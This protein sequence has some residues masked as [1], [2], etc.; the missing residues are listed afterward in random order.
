MIQSMTGYGTGLARRDETSVT[1][2]IRTVNHRFLDMHIRVPRD[3]AYLEMDIQ[4]VIRGALTRGRVD[5]SVSI[6]AAASPELL[7]NSSTVRT[8][9][10][11]AALLRDKFQFQDALDLKTL[12]SLPGVL[13]NREA[14]MGAA[15]DRGIQETVLEALKQALDGVSTMRRQEGG[16]LHAEMTRHLDSIRGRTDS[17]G[18]LAPGTVMEYKSKLEER[19]A[20]LLPQN[21]L[22]PQRVAMEVALLAEKSDISEEV[23]RLRSHTEQFSRM[24]DTGEQV[25]K[26]LDFLLQEMQRESNTILAKAANLE[27]TRLGIAIKSEIEKLREQVQN[28]E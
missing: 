1:V 24:L 14:A 10:E 22:D 28:V 17:I 26:K 6:E 27:I 23:A 2:E 21:G 4:P 13:Q 20:Q 7:V 16:A 12:L 3:H 15:G 11:A 5:V 19:L 25:G 8:Y 18:I 9:I